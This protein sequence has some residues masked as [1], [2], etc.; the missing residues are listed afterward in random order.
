MG[1]M[2]RDPVTLPEAQPPAGG[3]SGPTGAEGVVRGAQPGDLLLV[4]TTRF[5]YRLGRGLTR[6][7]FDHI[8]VVL[9]G[10]NTLN[11]VHPRAVVLPAHVFAKPGSSPLVL[12]PRWGGPGQ[13]KAFLKGMHGFLGAPYAFWRTVA[14]I[15]VLGLDTWLAVRLPMR[16]PRPTAPRWI[17]TEAILEG[18]VRACPDFRAIDRLDLDYNKLG[19]A[20]TNDFLRIAARLPDLLR[21]VARSR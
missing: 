19:F 18:L 16:K 8:A 3:T 1:F 13:R 10:G 12:R 11:I 4:R 17:C 15:V 6:N 21:C 20:T 5:G 14:G 7:I 9:P 2:L